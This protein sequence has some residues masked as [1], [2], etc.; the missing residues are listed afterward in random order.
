MPR[1]SHRLPQKSLK[2]QSEVIGMEASNPLQDVVLNYSRDLSYSGNKNTVSSSFS[3][4]EQ[5][6]KFYLLKW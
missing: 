2:Q 4:K 3:Q 5:N 1:S 6:G